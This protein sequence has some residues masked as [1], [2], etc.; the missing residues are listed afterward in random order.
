MSA[1]KF[2]FVSPGVFLNEIDQSQLPKT[3]V[4]VGPAIIGRTARGPAFRPTQVQSFSEFVEVFGEPAPGNRLTAD[5]WRDGT[6]QGPTYAAYAAQAYLRNNGPVTI[7]RLL[8]DQHDNNDGSA[9]ALAGYRIGAAGGSVNSSAANGGAFGLFVF[10]S[11]SCASDSFAVESVTGTLGAIFY[12]SEGAVELTGTVRA[13]EAK[14]A[15]NVSGTMVAVQSDGNSDKGFSVLI[16]NST[17][18]ADS[19]AGANAARFNFNFNPDSDKYIRRV[20]NTDPTRLN[21]TITTTDAQETYFLGQSYERAVQNMLERSPN[22]VSSDMFAIMMPLQ[23]SAIS[24]A[25]Y[26][27]KARAAESGWVVSQDLRNTA[28]NK[29]NSS[30]NA[31]SFDPES[32]DVQKLFKIKGLTEGAWTH[33]NI[34]ISIE[35]I[36]ASP[37]NFNK[38]GSFSVVVRRIE[39]NDRIPVVIE[40]FDNLNLNPYSPD[41]IATRIGDMHVRYDFDRGRLQEVGTYPNRSSFI[42]VEMSNQI[43]SGQGDP[44]LLPFGFHGPVTY[45]HFTVATDVPTDSDLQGF[46]SA[47]L[48]ASISGSTILYQIGVSTAYHNSYGGSGSVDGTIQGVFVRA[49]DADATAAS[50]EQNNFL[51]IDVKFEFPTHR[52][53]GDSSEFGLNDHRKVYFG[54]DTTKTG[55]QNLAFDASNIDIAHPLAAGIADSFAPGATST[56][57]YVFTLDNLSGT[58]NATD[59][60]KAIYSRFTYVSG[61]RAAGDSITAATG[62]YKAV[63]K[64]FKDVGGARFT[65][66][67]F[68][69]SDGFDAREKEPFNHHTQLAQGAGST[70]HYG[71]YTMRK[72]LDIITDP[73]FVEMNLAAMPGVTNENLT[74]Q[75]IN[76][77]EERGDALAII[78]PDGGY[79]P[80]T[81]ASTSE[82]DRV[83]ATAAQDVADNMVARNIN[84]SYGA[85][86]FPWVQIRDSFRGN[87]VFVPPSVVAL[88]VLGASEAKSAVWF[89]PAG[90]NRGGLNESGAGLAVT[91]VRHKLTSGERDRLYEANINPIASFPSEGIVVFGQK[92]LQVTP[93]ALDRINVRRLMIFIKRGMSRIAN[94]VLFDQNLQ[95]TWTRFKDR[96]DTFL[97]NVK[98]GFGLED[99]KVVLDET[100]TTADLVDRNIMY[101]KVF[102]KPAKAIE[103]I[104]LDF[105]VT[106]S[107]ASFED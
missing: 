94:T 57:S 28:G 50:A 89:A 21:S 48:E 107:G 5:Q 81:D 93:S 75:L 71:Y 91:G 74:E 6:P 34:K 63:L 42:R 10:P 43:D 19:A 24:A 101:A 78:D 31:I 76:I 15:Y 27:I 20:F 59:A 96:A 29:T 51:D 26:R 4:A 65:M 41:Y 14:Q 11:S 98:A 46:G 83:V 105:I 25:N 82:A 106:R 3:A 35:R 64:A 40:R 54:I 2:K 37:D 67:L 86:Y 44:E 73:E 13:H 8:G 56:T 69:G 52:L 72:G 104:A 39:D 33:K 88:G 103:F 47:N 68:G 38:Y 70:T 9:A 22:G 61:S 102:I 45:N 55:S 58:S 60:S 97:G 18:A 7:V 90:F 1:K 36:K 30:E 99:F 53:V 95:A 17:E 100:T 80:S 92:T 62:S 66:P 12:T 49:N 84:S 16:K 85:A 77:C 79:T 87:L 23:T 32:S